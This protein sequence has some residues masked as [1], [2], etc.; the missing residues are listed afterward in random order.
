MGS[1]RYLQTGTD[2]WKRAT[3]VDVFWF[4]PADTGGPLSYRK[5]GRPDPTI[6]LHI[7]KVA[8]LP[9][10]VSAWHLYGNSETGPLCGIDKS[11]TLEAL[12]LHGKSRE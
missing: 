1:L 3:D 8:V 4:V 2:K 7:R 5:L 12:E 10:E 9:G 11:R 6:R